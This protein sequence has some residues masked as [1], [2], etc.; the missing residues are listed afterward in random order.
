MPLQKMKQKM[1]HSSCTEDRIQ[2]ALQRCLCGLGLDF[3]DKQLWNAGLC[4]NR[5]CLEELVKRDPRNFLIL[6]QQILRKTKEVLLQCQYELVVPLALMFTSTLMN[7]PHVPPDCGVLQEAYLLFHSFLSWP[8]PCCSAIKNL[9]NI[10]QQELRAPGISFQRLVKTE[11]DFTPEIHSS[12]V[13]T[14]LLVSPDEDVPPE[15]QAVS[16]QLSSTRRSHRDIA[17]GLI[18]HGLQ[19][20]LGAKHSL[21]THHTIL[22][23]G[24]PMLSFLTLSIYLMFNSSSDDTCRLSFFL[25]DQTA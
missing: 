14:V 12:K 18:L 23:V 3:P 22:Q 17:V 20:A 8:E 24:K 7:T 6:L 10:I 9:L 25:P 13:M 2:H 11:Q 5:W 21:Q 4:I 1:E 19:A 15:V 16:E